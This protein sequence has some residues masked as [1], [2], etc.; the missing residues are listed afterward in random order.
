MKIFK[1]NDIKTSIKCLTLFFIILSM[2]LIG[3]SIFLFLQTR[4]VISGSESLNSS[5]PQIS[6]MI[7]N[8]FLLNIITTTSL[9]AIMIFLYFLIRSYAKSKLADIKEAAFF[10]P[11]TS[12]LN[13]KSFLN[14]LFLEVRR[15]ARNNFNIALI[16][17]NI[18][19]FSV[20]N[21]RFNNDIGD[22][23]LKDISSVIKTA[24]RRHDQVCRWRADEFMI[25]LPETSLTGA[26]TAA[27]KIRK[28]IEDHVIKIKNNEIKV[29]MSFGTSVITANSLKF[30]EAIDRTEIQIQ[31]AKKTGKNRVK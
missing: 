8:I 5:I 19:D 7:N 15:G 25:M 29:T 26:Q 27:E 2:L 18:D 20:I 30:S 1:E 17:G 9:A 16:L 24:L 21:S 3:L 10:D 22:I 6:T 28:L 11:L 31:L 23:V 13:K 14:A 12:L 4:S